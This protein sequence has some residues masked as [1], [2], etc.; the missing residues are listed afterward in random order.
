MVSNKQTCEHRNAVIA[1]K[2]NIIH[3]Q[4][5]QRRQ[6]I[7]LQH[8]ITTSIKIRTYIGVSKLF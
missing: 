1:V 5:Y 6:T 4:M 8:N 3:T 2:I 7:K